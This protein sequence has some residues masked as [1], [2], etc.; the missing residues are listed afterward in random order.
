MKTVYLTY[1]NN[2]RARSN[3]VFWHFT[4]TDR[5]NK[6]GR[7][8]SREFSSQ[9]RAPFCGT[10]AV[11]KMSGLSRSILFMSFIARCKQR[12]EVLH[13]TLYSADSTPAANPV[14]NGQ[15]SLQQYT[16]MFQ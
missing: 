16:L 5:W 2:W 1:L 15:P 6:F 13:E 3:E 7:W 8:G 12:G 11:A 9:T 10:L 14:N 4:N